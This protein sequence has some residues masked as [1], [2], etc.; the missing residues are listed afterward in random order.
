MIAQVSATSV[1]VSWT[2]PTDTTGVTGYQIFYDDGTGEQ[3]ED[4]TGSGMTTAKIS[5][6]TTGSTYYITIVATSNGLP[7]KVVGPEMGM[8][9]AFIILYIA[10]FT[11]TFGLL[12]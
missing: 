4:V 2:P 9:C 12:L 8:R 6:L 5:G 11:L 1:I 7:S 10:S 3:F